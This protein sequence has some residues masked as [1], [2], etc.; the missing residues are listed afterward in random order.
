MKYLE[1]IRCLTETG[2]REAIEYGE[3]HAKDHFWAILLTLNSLEAVGDEQP[4][5]VCGPRGRYDSVDNKDNVLLVAYFLSKFGHHDLFPNQRFN[6]GEAIAAAAKILGVKPNTLKNQRDFFDSY[7]G[8]GREGWK[9]P[10]NPAQQAMF[11][12]LQSLDKHTVLER[13]RMVLG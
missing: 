3:S 6:Q 1:E 7:T 8:S 9:V 2:Y 4:R 13:V 10:L 11:D 5:S 12:Q